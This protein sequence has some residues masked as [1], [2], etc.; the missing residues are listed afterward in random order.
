[1]RNSFQ[2]KVVLVTGASQ[3]IG[4]DIALSFA[5]EG[6]RLVLAARSAERL[7]GVVEEI[8]KLGAEA[9]AVPTDVGNAESVRA[10][11]ESAMTRFGR[12]DVLV[13][14]AGIARVAPIES[15][16]FENDLRDTQNASLFGMIRVTQSVLP[17]FR[18]QG[19][20]TIVNMS[21]VMGRK[22]FGRFGAYAIVMHGVSAFSDALRQE[23]AGT[24][25][26]VL[27]V[28]PALTAT[29]LLAEADPL[30]MP[31]PFAHMTP[32]SS[33]YVGHAVVSAVRRGKRRLIM[34]RMANMLLF[35]EAL[36]PRIGDLIAKAL[37]I[38]PIAWSLG[39]YRGKTYHQLLPSL[40]S[41]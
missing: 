18:R 25:I 33:R 12:L 6:A 31:A 19:S 1:M 38:K 41:A 11:I 8:G 40:A 39:M 14:N 29:R 13:N 9:I 35:G 17:I 34:P 32:M 22:A 20:G 26:H 23:L 36:S 3:G 7:A 30:Q 24:G 15:A 28:H 5:R 10:L 2:E 4:K 21:S 37:S 16:G 27:I